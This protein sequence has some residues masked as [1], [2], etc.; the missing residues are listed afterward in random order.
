ML[1]ILLPGCV[2]VEP[3]TQPAAALPDCE[4]HRIDAL[5]WDLPDDYQLGDSGSVDFDVP[6]TAIKSYLNVT[7]QTAATTQMDLRIDSNRTTAWSSGGAM[8]FSFAN[9]PSTRTH[10]VVLTGPST[11]F[12]DLEGHVDL[13]RVTVETLYCA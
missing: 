7:R 8:G 3:S 6:A 5:E 10:I 2:D 4:V 11:F 9:S 13:L 12:W 1:V